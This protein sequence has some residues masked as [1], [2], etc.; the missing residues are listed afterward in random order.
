M[1]RLK[2]L[3]VLIG[4]AL[5]LIPTDQYSLGDGCPWDYY[6]A[7]IQLTV[8]VVDCTTGEP[9]PSARVEIYYD[10][11]R[12]DRG[13]TNAYG[14]FST[15]FDLCL[16][17]WEDTEDAILELIEEE[18]LE[19]RVAKTGYS[20]PR[21]T[22][23]RVV[24]VF[25]STIA[26]W[27]A[28]VH[29]D[30]CMERENQPPNASFT[31]TPT[32]PHVMEPISFDASPSSD[33]EG[34]ITG[35]RWDFG[36]GSEVPPSG[37]LLHPQAIHTYN[38]PGTY[39]VQLT[40]K[41]ETGLTASTTRTI[42]VA[43]AQACKVEI[44]PDHPTS[45]DSITITVSGTFPD[46]CYTLTHRLQVVGKEIRITGQVL[47]TEEPGILCPQVVT[48]WSFSERV[49]PLPPGQYE[50]IVD[51]E[52]GC[53]WE[54]TLDVSPWAQAGC[55]LSTPDLVYCLGSPIPIY[56]M[57]PT[58]VGSDFFSCEIRPFIPGAPGAP[59]R[60]FWLWGLAAHSSIT[61]TWDGRD[62]T[63]MLVPPGLYLISCGCATSTL[64][65]SI[66]DCSSPIV[67]RP[68]RHHI[69]R[70]RPTA[71]SIGG[72]GPQA[73]PTAPECQSPPL[74]T[75]DFADPTSG[76]P[77][78]EGVCGYLP[79]LEEYFISIADPD[80]LKPAVNGRF[81]PPSDLC[82]Q[83]IA[84]PATGPEHL[85][86]GLVFRYQD[87]QNFYAF[88]VNSMGMYAL[89]LRQ[90]GEYTPLIA[91]QPSTAIYQGASANLLKVIVRGTLIN[92][93]VNGQFLATVE[94]D[95]LTE[96]SIGLYGGPGLYVRFDDLEVANA[97]W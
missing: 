87:D 21:I 72:Q 96:G 24:A 93:Y 15:I 52:Q 60:S 71:A 33:T 94:D 68:P 83:A 69:S 75:D 19:I 31:Y 8:K 23:A 73:E 55:R 77:E 65:I 2:V 20:R 89:Y 49:G 17:E 48:P 67:V 42:V 56:V 16:P 58:G 11:E 44:V 25:R 79:E 80:S 46:P 47:Q 82:Y 34:T 40:V 28:I 66:L 51:I 18:Y 12:Y 37:W 27:R 53:Q 45:K 97:G 29:V 95:T 13:Y 54:G 39:R 74:F 3:P 5:A 36:D 59:V 30:V 81:Q 14:N 90:N 84:Q 32:Q 26:P 64:A 7:T 61:F 63:G 38:A 43:P 76:W 62:A 10:R 9:I 86:Y 35:Y 91:F 50:V 85:P 88:V 70:P 22:Q 92:L 1:A 78:E 6:L 4:A 41:D 57:N